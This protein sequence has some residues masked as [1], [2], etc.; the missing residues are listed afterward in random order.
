MH[1]A[2]DE[3]PL[4]E[5]AGL[6]T[7]GFRGYDVPVVFDV[8]GLLERV[9]V[10]GVD[11][12]ASVVVEAGG[13]P[14]GVA[15]V[16]VRGLARRVIAMAVVPEH[17]GSGLGRALLA[18]VLTEATAAGCRA[19]ELEVLSHNA[20]A[21]GLYRSMG[22]EPV[23]ELLSFEIDALPPEGADGPDGPEVERADPRE[24]A[25]ILADVADLPWQIAPATL[26]NLGP[27]RR[28]Y[29]LGPAVAVLS[30]VQG[31]RCMLRAIG[32]RR[33]ARRAGHGRRLLA[34]L[35]RHHRGV[36][37]QVPAL[38]PEGV[39]G[40]FRATGFRPGRHTQHHLRVELPWTP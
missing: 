31:G 14:V 6:V 39:A 1:R 35:G 12:A 8:R 10:D 37:V 24:L 16:A 26:A 18:R 28:A 13:G 15:L 40:F 27:S 4:A 19:V 32:V 7:A 29:R 30:G 2:A 23:Q 34:A 36:A 21:V 3:L 20:G 38:A 17:R 5:V 9:R 33:E 11:L 25:R 22:F